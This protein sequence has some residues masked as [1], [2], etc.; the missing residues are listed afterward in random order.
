MMRATISLATLAALV[1]FAG[2][3]WAQQP[4]APAAPA[5]VVEATPPD[6]WV[7]DQ[8]G[9]AAH[10]KA[11]RESHAGTKTTAVSFRSKERGG[12][13]LVGE[14]RFE[15]AP[16][17]VVTVARAEL[18]SLR[19]VVESVGGTLVTWRFLGGDPL[20][21]EARL[22]WKDPSVGT[23]SITRALVVRTAGS[24]SIVT[25]ECVIAA[26]AEALR[27]PCEAALNAL[28]PAAGLARVE[29]G[30]GAGDPAAAPVPEPP[31]GAP[32]SAPQLGE[33]PVD[34]PSTILV[35]PP[36]TESKPDRRPLYLVAGIAVLAVVFL[37]NRRQRARLEAA[38]AR[39]RRASRR[40]DGDR[41]D[42][43]DDRDD[44]QDRTA[45]AGP[46]DSPA[47]DDRDEK[48]DDDR[49]DKEPS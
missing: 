1:G 6:G 16:A 28:R 26:D 45:N 48:R 31:A 24:L 5:S 32:R 44:D 25:A 18:A 15:P 27:A 39:E 9:S 40:R 8:P 37:W 47:D 4:E 43:R 23:T 10:A 12:A 11:L 29:V 3:A 33:G 17:D 19:A 30:L 2:Q 46:D 49:D 14:V 35:R 41:D 34:M 36:S 7:L 42:D 20:L 13:L 21:P 38:E 22:E